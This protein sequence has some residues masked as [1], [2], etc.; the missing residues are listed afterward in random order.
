MDWALFLARKL[1]L[2]KN[3]RVLYMT[4]EESFQTIALI[5]RKMYKEETGDD[6]FPLSE[7]LEVYR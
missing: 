5:L 2:L 3:D 7:V 6:D 1:K 4:E